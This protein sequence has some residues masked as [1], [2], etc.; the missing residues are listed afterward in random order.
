[1]GYLYF[2][3]QIILAVL[4]GG[5]IGWQREHS[6][7]EAGPRTYALITLGAALFTI[8]SMDAFSGAESSRVAAQIVTGIGF[9]GAGTILHKKNTIEGLTTAAGMWAAAIGMAIGVGWL[10]ESVIV[11]VIIFLVLLFNDNRLFKK[12]QCKDK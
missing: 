9:I 2:T 11:T 6:G 7:K 1:M 8:L 12:D 3:I 10:W 5:I 4:L